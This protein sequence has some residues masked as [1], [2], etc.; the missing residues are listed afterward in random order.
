[1]ALKGQSQ[2]SRTAATM[3][4]ACTTTSSSRCS[5]T[6]EIFSLNERCHPCQTMTKRTNN[7]MLAQLLETLRV[8]AKNEIEQSWK[9]VETVKKRCAAKLR[10]LTRLHFLIEASKDRK[11]A[12]IEK[13]AWINVK[14]NELQ[15]QRRESQPSLCS[16]DSKS[17][18]ST[19]RF[20]RA[21]FTFK[22]RRC[23]EALEKA[24]YDDLKMESRDQNIATL[25]E[26][27]EESRVVIQ[28]LREKRWS[29]VQERLLRIT[30]IKP[31]IMPRFQDELSIRM[32]MA[33]RINYDLQ[34]AQE[35]K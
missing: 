35:I 10:T 1:M 22:R 34:S 3:D 29:R 31:S 16:H 26:S 7:I 20:K 32:A 28:V 8:E 2:S 24:D 11:C 18:K 19:F 21:M 13:L 25:R 15:Q 17:I 33:C 6:D 4:D 23:L 9:E 30:T 5:G 14:K 12:A 27:L